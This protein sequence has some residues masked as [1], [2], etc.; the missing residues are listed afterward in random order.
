MRQQSDEST[1][2][3]ES[4][5]FEQLPKPPSSYVIVEESPT[6][7]DPEPYRSPSPCINIKTTRTSE[8]KQ[9][10]DLVIIQLPISVTLHE[11]KESAECPHVEPIRS[12]SPGKIEIR[13]EINP[14]LN[15]HPII[16][17]N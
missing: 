17:L 14:L 15:Q 9:E 3:T 16:K 8:I 4:P 7:S 1:S 10:I 12:P 6:S 13:K 2:L 5:T 11:M